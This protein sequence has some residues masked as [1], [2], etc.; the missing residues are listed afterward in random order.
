MRLESTDDRRR[1]TGIE[2]AT[3]QQLLQG[4]DSREGCELTVGATWGQTSE[5]EVQDKGEAT[6]VEERLRSRLPG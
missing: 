6:R 1:R 2:A 3:A 4:V 5:E